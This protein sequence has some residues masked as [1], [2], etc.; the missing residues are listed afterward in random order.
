[1]KRI[2]EFTAEELYLIWD[3]ARGDCQDGFTDVLEYIKAN[4]DTTPTKGESMSVEEIVKIIVENSNGALVYDGIVALLLAK[5]IQ[6][7]T[8]QQGVTIDWSKAPGWA[9]YVNLYWAKIESFSAFHTI[10]RPI[11]RPATKTR[12]M[13]REEKVTLLVTAYILP[14][15][16]SVTDK[17]SDSTIDDLCKAAGINTEVTL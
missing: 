9:D 6:P 15:N 14:Y 13:T 4:L 17:L 16:V 2:E 8:V 10:P 3:G 12:S 5:A 1:M 7:L 11:P